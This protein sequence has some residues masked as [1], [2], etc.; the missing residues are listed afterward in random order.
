MGD[1]RGH[2]QRHRLVRL[3]RCSVYQVL[4][5]FLVGNITAV[6]VAVQCCSGCVTLGAETDASAAVCSRGLDFG[7]H[8]PYWLQ[9]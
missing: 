3:N 1:S 6:A 9:Y 8:F 4:F 5:L 2:W 7:G